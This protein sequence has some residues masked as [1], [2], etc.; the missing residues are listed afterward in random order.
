MSKFSPINRTIF[1]LIFLLFS[2]TLIQ[3]Q[4]LPELSSWLS[5]TVNETRASFRMQES[6][7]HEGLAQV[8]VELEMSAARRALYNNITLRIYQDDGSGTFGIER[9]SES[10]EPGDDGRVPFTQTVKTRVLVTGLGAMQNLRAQVEVSGMAPRDNFSFHTPACMTIIETQDVWDPCGSIAN[11]ADFPGLVPYGTLGIGGI[12]NDHTDYHRFQIN[13][14]NRRLK[15]TLSYWNDYHTNPPNL[16]IDLLILNGNSDILA[17]NTSAATSTTL[18]I[19]ESIDIVLPVGTYY[20]VIAPVPSVNFI[21]NHYRLA[22]TVEATPE[23]TISGQILQDGGL[24]LE[25]V[26]FNSVPGPVITDVNGN[27]SITVPHGWSGTAIPS[28]APYSYTPSSRSYSNVTGDMNNQDYVATELSVQ[29]SGS[30]VYGQGTGLGGVDLQGFTDPVTT[31]ANGFYHAE[32]SYNWSGVITP[33]TEGINFTPESR[34][35]SELKAN[36]YDQDYEAQWEEYRVDGTVTLAGSG[37]ALPGVIIDGSPGPSTSDEQGRF[38]FHVTHGSHITLKSILEGYHFEPDPYNNINVTEDLTVDFVASLKYYS[39]IGHV[40]DQSGVGIED[41]EFKDLPGSPLTDEFGYYQAAVPHGWNGTATPELYGYTFSPGY[42]DYA[43]VTSGITTDYTGEKHPALELSPESIILPSE[44]GSMQEVT[45]NSSVDWTVT[46][47]A[48]WLTP[49]PAEGSGVGSFFA[50]ATSQ[51]TSLDP[52][53]TTVT[54]SGEGLSRTLDVRQEGDAPYLSISPTEVSLLEGSGASQTVVISTNTSW[55]FSTTASWFEIEPASGTGVT[56]VNVTSLED[57]PSI[58]PRSA[59]VDLSG[60]GL[61]TSLTITQNG[62]TPFLSLNPTSATLGPEAD[63]TT[64]IQVL[65]NTDWTAMKRSDWLQINP[66]SGSG[67]EMI[68]VRTESANNSSEVRRDTITLSTAGLSQDV[69]ITQEGAETGIS[70]FDSKQGMRLYPN[71][72]SGTVYLESQLEG[73][74]QLV[75]EL[76]D[77]TGRTL[78]QESLPFLSRGEIYELDLGPYPTGSY[79]LQLKS[80]Q[81]KMVFKVL[82]H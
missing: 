8:E 50:I 66:S 29:I 17:R 74:E 62:A 77:M 38:E 81:K 25:G 10:F 64:S 19:F 61:S 37:E 67:S 71:P 14:S 80:R 41:V 60:A 15:V 52:R 7:I 3:A 2:N 82:K 30:V 47:P 4:F 45:V 42:T 27:Y 9:Y 5:N 65:S 39:I 57:N 46:C 40:K 59:S 11:A 18:P 26:S 56:H 55:S 75:L 53:T 44:S 68:E 79:M 13:E 16:D 76:L 31:D 51:N 43:S 33:V 36:E 28:L 49:S 54:V 78:L 34:T 1:A 58:D 24:P 48:D 63:A 6:S 73:S 23:Y 35:Y 72:S 12:I 70:S 21:R 20:F 69:L 32:V 22:A